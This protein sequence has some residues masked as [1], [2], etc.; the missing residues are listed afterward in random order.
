MQC[1][2]FSVLAISASASCSKFQFTCSN[3][4]CIAIYDACDGMAHCSDGS[5][6]SN[7]GQASNGEFIM[8]FIL[9]MLV[10]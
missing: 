4:E 1:I 6:E 9:S 2:I 7:C 5:D 8:F 3:G 10:C